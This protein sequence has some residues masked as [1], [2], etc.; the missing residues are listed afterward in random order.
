MFRWPHEGWRRWWINTGTRHA[1]SVRELPR[2]KTNER[3]ELTLELVVGA[4][5]PSVVT[6]RPLPE[7]VEGKA[8]CHAG[9]HEIADPMSVRERR[10][11]DPDLSELPCRIQ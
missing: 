8:R 5:R 7:S 10:R 11:A 6:R 9:V 3:R 4:R 1:R 2:A